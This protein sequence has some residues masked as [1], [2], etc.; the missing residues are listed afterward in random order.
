MKEMRASGL[1]RIPSYLATITP[2]EM[3][4]ILTPVV[5][6]IDNSIQR[7]N[8]YPVDSVVCFANTYPLDSNLSGG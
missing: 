6:M 1:S 7:I 3:T 4:I 2:L 5:R 8:R